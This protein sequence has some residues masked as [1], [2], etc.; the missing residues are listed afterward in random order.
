MLI[1][2][3]FKKSV[4][5]ATA[6]CLT[7]IV[8]ITN[9][10]NRKEEEYMILKI[11]YYI[12]LLIVNIYSIY[13]V[14]TGIFTFKKSKKVKSPTKSNFFTILIPARNEE[15]VIANLIKS[16]QNQN[17]DQ[18]KY[19]IVVVLNNSTDNTYEVAKASGAKVYKCKNKITSK[20]DALKEA[21][22]KINDKKIDA[23]IVFD[24]DNV[25]DKNFLKH[26][27]DSLNSGYKVA[28]AF[29]DTKNAG[30]NWIANSYAIYYYIQNYFYNK[31]RKNMN[32]SASLNGTGFMVKKELLDE[33]GFNTKTMTEDI[34]LTGI[35]AFNGVKIDFVEKA[36]TYDEQPTNFKIS[37]T[38]RK[39]WSKGSLQCAK[40]YGSKLLK[41]FFKTGNLSCIDIIMTYI[42]PIIQI[43]AFV[44]LI[45]SLFV[46]VDHFNIINIIYNY[47]L[48]NVHAGIIFYLA[49][50]LLCIYVLIYNRKSLKKFFSGALMFGLFM[51]T[52][53]PINI[54]ILFQKKI[55][56]THIPHDKSISIDEV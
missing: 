28:Q 24:A 9:I 27:N 1:I 17:Y 2:A 42:S 15:N 36:V 11:I 22:D 45:L 18:E 29:R 23:Y 47:Y 10:D 33:I 40:E 3:C 25:V 30:D 52:W 31:A 37:W 51:I 21:F 44:G 48:M 26:M 8:I 5:Y 54:I 35:L 49:Q 50:V 53:I 13:F 34:E 55:N 7:N 12:L 39:R 32:L 56:W 38:Q 46:N 6:I 4:K 43:I 20:G 19:E 41:Q 16:L 14:I